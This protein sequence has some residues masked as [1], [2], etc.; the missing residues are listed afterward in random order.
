MTNTQAKTQTR[1]PAVK[2]AV[3]V[4]A[5]APVATELVRCLWI[6]DPGRGKTCHMAALAHLGKVI[7]LDAEN[8]LKK[9]VLQRLG[10]P[11]EN[12]ERYSKISYAGLE[13]L[14]F[15]LQ[16][17]IESGEAIA[18]VCFDSVTELHKLLLRELVDDAVLIAM[19]KDKVRA[20]WRTQLDDYGDMTNQLR[21]L[22]RRYRDLDIHLGFA[23]HAGR[24]L[25][26]EGRVR[27]TADLTKAAR[28]DLMGYVDIALNCQYTEWDGVPEFSAYTRPVGKF[29]AKDSFGV[30]PTMLI[31]PTFPRVIRYVN[32][33]LD[34]NTDPFQLAARA[35][36]AVAT[37]ADPTPAPAPTEMTPDA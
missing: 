22:L 3:Q 27:L 6:G 20:P 9:S 35:R 16:E 29:D 7:Y 32:S 25:D 2:P 1:K 34:R 12:I 31:E 17:R 4:P 24:D 26:E 36:R 13:A 18:G 30:L 8:R 5:P 10:I 37:G 15:K 14:S 21:I 33:E 23:A 11:T 28:S 19:E